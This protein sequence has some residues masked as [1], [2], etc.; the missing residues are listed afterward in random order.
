MK[1][2][3]TGKRS[4]E[5]VRALVWFAARE[6]EIS[7]YVRD[8]EVTSCTGAY[9]GRC[10][11]RRILLRIGPDS[12]FPVEAKYPGLVTAPTFEM[13]D[14]VEGLVA[15]AAHEFAHSRQFR[16]NTRRSE[17]EAERI[18]VYV[19]EKFRTCRNAVL[20]PALLAAKVRD[21]RVRSAADRAPA[22]KIVA[23]E[24]RLKLW[25]TREKRAANLVKKYERRLARARRRVS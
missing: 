9:R 6:L 10:W 5:V 13:R 23:I 22:L 11:G 15:I 25:R 21:G 18:A 1:I 4:P 3:V 19:L 16:A 2:S 12:D 17:V 20:E 8:V 24:E 14:W 7:D